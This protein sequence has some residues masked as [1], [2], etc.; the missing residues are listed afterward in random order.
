MR[1]KINDHD[2]L[3]LDEWLHALAVE[4]SVQKAV[5]TDLKVRACP[6]HK[7]TEEDAAR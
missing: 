3:T 7:Y 5:S 1:F 2:V 6:W 4:V